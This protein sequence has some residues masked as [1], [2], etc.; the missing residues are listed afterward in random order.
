MRIVC[1][2]IHITTYVNNIKVSD[3]DGSGVLDNEEH[4]KNKVSK[5]GHIAIPLHRKANNFIRYKGVE[6][7]IL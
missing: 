4:V 5:K 1:K 3:Y 6:I 7:R 2:G